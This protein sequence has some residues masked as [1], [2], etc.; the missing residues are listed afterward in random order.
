MNSNPVYKLPYIEINLV[1]RSTA[2]K[3]YLLH[4]FCFDPGLKGFK[5][6][7]LTKFALYIC[8]WKEFNIFSDV[9]PSQF[10]TTAQ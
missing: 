6:D 8:K 7:T 10:K 4:T 5:N 2:N 3:M 1:E 9:P